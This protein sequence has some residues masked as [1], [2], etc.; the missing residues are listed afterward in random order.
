ML[1]LGG[2]KSL[3]LRNNM[4]IPSASGTVVS[5]PIP[6]YQNVPIHAEYFKPS[7]FVISAIGLGTTTTIT[8]T[9]DMN[10]QIGQEIRLLIPNEF[11]S[12][13]LNDVTGFVIEISATNQVVTNIN[14]SVNVDA[15]I[16][17]TPT[18]PLMKAYSKAQ[19]IAIGDIRT[20]ANNVDGN[21]NTLTYIPGSFRNISPQ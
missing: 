16:A 2:V 9:A 5:Y 11:G 20:G 14:S 10:Y 7:R 19:I 17:F 3:P 21:M 13:Q 4:A 8:A 18:Q 1:H 6:A 12:Y 15:F